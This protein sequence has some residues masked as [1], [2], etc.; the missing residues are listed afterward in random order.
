MVSLL[1]EAGVFRKPE[2]RYILAAMAMM[3]VV[4][5]TGTPVSN[6]TYL[7]NIPGR[8]L[9]I[10]SDIP[11]IID[12]L[13]ADRPLVAIGDYWFVTPL[14]YERIRLQGNRETYMISARSGPLRETIRHL[15]ESKRSFT[16]G[17]VVTKAEDCKVILGQWSGTDTSGQRFTLDFSA[18]LESGSM[19]TVFSVEPTR[20]QPSIGPDKARS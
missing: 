16:L 12:H 13:P 4:M 2:G 7:S 11:R 8:E 14:V 15:V 1:R 6:F 3:A 5:R 19:I 18:A 10:N 20:I 9:A 17:C